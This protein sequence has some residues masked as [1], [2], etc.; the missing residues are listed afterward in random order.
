MLGFVC[1]LLFFGSLVFL[2]IQVDCLKR[3]RRFH[4]FSLGVCEC[5]Y[6]NVNAV[7]TLKARRIC[8]PRKWLWTACCGYWEPDSGP[9][10]E[11]CIFTTEP[12]P[13]T[14]YRVNKNLFY[15][16]VMGVIVGLT[17]IFLCENLSC[18]DSTTLSLYNWIM[19]IHYSETP[20]CQ[21]VSCL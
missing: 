10:G 3:F 6:V 11:H 18:V 8:S 1:F 19:I 7:P 2:I 14:S 4:Y 13:P 12:S 9:L 15:L 16:S 20:A 17:L 5:R 21:L